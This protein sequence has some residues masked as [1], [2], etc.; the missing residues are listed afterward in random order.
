MANSGNNV[1]VPPYELVRNMAKRLSRQEMEDLVSILERQIRKKRRREAML[2]RMEENA[3][4]FSLWKRKRYARKERRASEAEWNK[5]NDKMNESDPDEE[6]EEEIH[7][8]FPEED[9]MVEIDTKES[10]QKRNEWLFKKYEKE[11]NKYPAKF[12]KTM[13]EP[14]DSG[15]DSDDEENEDEDAVMGDYGTPASSHTEE[16]ESSDV[17]DSGDDSDG[18]NSFLLA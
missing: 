6:N 12:A 13:N 11:K 4:E 5:V 14:L 1:P 8:T 9:E 15:S 16:E 17:S 7:E 18:G 3:E 10:G 2:Q